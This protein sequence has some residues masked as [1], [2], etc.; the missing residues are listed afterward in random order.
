MWHSS[1]EFQAL[2]AQLKSLKEAKPKAT[3]IVALGIGSLH[4]MRAK[5]SAS[6]R[7]SRV[8]LATVLTISS[9]LSGWS[10]LLRNCY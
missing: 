10:T 8:Q 3:N 7:R 6:A 1:P 2:T 9:Y 4:D 5:D